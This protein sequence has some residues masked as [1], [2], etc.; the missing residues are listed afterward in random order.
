[1]VDCPCF[2]FSFSSKVETHYSKSQRA[3]QLKLRDSTP[4]SPKSCQV[5]GM[6]TG[7]D[8]L[9]TEVVTGIL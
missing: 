8:V 7:I 1:M 4:R 6:V 9:A 3:Q 2:G 5:T